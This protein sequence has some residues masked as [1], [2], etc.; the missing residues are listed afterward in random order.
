MT[1]EVAQSGRTG[2]YVR[3]LSGGTLMAGFDLELAG[4]P[5][6]NWPVA[7]ANDVLFGREVDRMSV[8]ELMNLPKLSREWKDAL[9]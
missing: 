5:N 9:A 1:K 3:V 7:R 8:H 4:R 2:W 6:P